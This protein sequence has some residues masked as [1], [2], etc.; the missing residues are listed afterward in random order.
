MA[1][2]RSAIHQVPVKGATLELQAMKETDIPDA[3]LREMLDLLDAAFDGWPEFRADIEPLEHLRWKMQSPGFEYGAILGHID[4]RLVSMRTLARWEFRVRGVDREMID[5]ADSSVLPELQGRGIDTAADELAR[6]LFPSEV[7]FDNS[8]DRERVRLRGTPLGNRVRR[9]LKPLRPWTFARGV[10]SEGSRLPA[11]VIAGATAT[12]SRWSQLRYRG[13]RAAGAEIRVAEL[14]GFDERFD[15]LWETAAR[16]YEL[17]G[18]R[19]SAFLAW[20][21]DPRGS[22]YRI[23]GALDARDRLLGYAVTTIHGGRGYIA[24]ML[25]LPSRR[26]V[27]ARLVEVAVDGFRQREASAATCWVPLVHPYYRVLRSSGFTDPRKDGNIY[28]RTG[29]R[30]REE[31]AFLAN[32]K[33]RLHVMHGDTDVV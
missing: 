22:D 33:A 21:Y 29:T 16:P 18:V 31:L 32:P 12:L 5:A 9:L 30:P 17:I 27:A 8:P 11:P 1:R 2:E 3:Q 28:Y 26:D 23:L 24:D 7:A 4:G 14:G 25:A 6:E 10:R 13:P 15:T 19:S 20:R